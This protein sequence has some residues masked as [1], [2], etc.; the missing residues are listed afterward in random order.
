VT[1]TRRTLLH[2]GAFTGIVLLAG[3]LDGAPTDGSGG[4][5]GSDSDGSD[6]SDSD[7]PGG[8]DEP[9]DSATDGAGGTRPT[10]TGGPGITLVEV[11]DPPELPVRPSIEIV[12]EAATTD[13][14]PQLR[15]TVV[16]ESDE[17]VSVGEGR[18]IVFA[19]VT[20]ESGELVLLPAGETYPA[21]ADCWRLT[22][23]IAVTEEYRTVTLEPG[24]STTALVDLYGTPDGDGCLPVGEHRF[25]TTISAAV[26]PDAMASEGSS[27]R[28]GFSVLLE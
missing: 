9:D 16:N 2:A 14:P 11:D 8:S 18:A 5:D 17:P 25:S 6:G 13:H 22:E 1:P 12:R 27:A 4:G 21:E 7:D 19:Y 26:G 23:G 28:W 15:A 20:A 10:G 24:E 3:C